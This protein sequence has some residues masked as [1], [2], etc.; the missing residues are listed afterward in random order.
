[1]SSDEINEINKD[2][3]YDTNSSINNINRIK[4]DTNNNNFYNQIHQIKK[5]WEN[6]S[7]NNSNNSRIATLHD[8]ELNRSTIY[9]NNL[10]NTSDFHLDTNSNNT[11]NNLNISQITID[12]LKNKWN[13]VSKRMNHMNNQNHSTLNEHPSS[14]QMFDSNKKQSNVNSHNDFNKRKSTKK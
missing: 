10:H 8:N 1:M 4:K 12:G 11:S 6:L 9:T 2:K 5:K 14:G 3:V 13:Q 7:N